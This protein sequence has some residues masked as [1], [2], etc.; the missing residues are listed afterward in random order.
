MDYFIFSHPKD[1]KAPLPRL[2]HLPLLTHY[3]K[4]F[5]SPDGAF[6]VTAFRDDT[7]VLW[8]SATLAVRKY[9]AW[10]HCM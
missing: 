9:G 1:I 5:F 6:L 3:F 8:N 2:I 10:N 4:V 7:M